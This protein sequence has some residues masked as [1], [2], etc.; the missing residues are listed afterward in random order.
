MRQDTRKVVVIVI[1]YVEETCQV[2]VSLKRR[3]VLVS[4][5]YIAPMGKH[6]ILSLVGSITASRLYMTA[7]FLSS[8]MY[9]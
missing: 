5:E 1:T 7:P 8:A 6:D 9:K 4:K 2:H 3:S